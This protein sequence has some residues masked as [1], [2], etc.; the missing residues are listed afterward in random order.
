MW[1]RGWTIK[2]WMGVV[3]RSWNNETNVAASLHSLSYSLQLW[4]KSVFGNIFQR[5][6]RMLRCLEGMQAALARSPTTALLKLED[7][8][9]ND[10]NG[11]QRQEESIWMQKLH[12]DWLHLGDRNTRF[13]HTSMIIHCRR[14]KVDCLQDEAGTWV[15]DQTHLKDMAVA[16]Y[17]GLF[18][19]DVQA[20]VP[21]SRGSFPPLL[22]SKLDLLQA[23]CNEEEVLCAIREMGPF[24]APG[25]DGFQACFF[26][27][28]WTTTGQA[29]T[30]MVQ[31][32][33]AGGNLPDGIVD[34][35]Q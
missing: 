11:T 7:K 34:V 30:S 33:L 23:H 21:F 27:R 1:P 2:A 17:S 26:Q 19:Y 22:P 14:N 3:Q 4:N 8:L 6:R 29:V 35:L 18:R 16:F 25:P 32:L 9:R 13:F 28:T 5:K 12:L 15:F 31:K 10:L 24:H 20:L